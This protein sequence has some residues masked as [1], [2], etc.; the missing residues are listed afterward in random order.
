LFL[1]QAWAS[2]PARCAK[3][4]VPEGA[5][6]HQ[7]KPELAMAM[8]VAARARGST[9]QWVGGDEV[10][11]NS[12]ACT[13]ALEDLGEVFLMDVAGSRKVR[14]GDPG[15]QQPPPSRGIA[16]A[17]PRIEARPAALWP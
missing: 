14:T 2:D 13:A 4:K 6:V 10:Y 17:A 1:P 3:A 5:R 15:P 12:H 8:V 16:R 7:T 11:G 9:H